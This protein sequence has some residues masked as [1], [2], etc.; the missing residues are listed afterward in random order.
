MGLAVELYFDAETE[1]AVRA[2]RELVHAAGVPVCADLQNSRPHITLAV[3]E[4][5]DDTGLASAVDRFI[6][7]EPSFCPV[8]LST[9]GS[10]PTEK[11]VLFLAPVPTAGLLDLHRSVFELLSAAG[12]VGEF[13]QPDH[14]VPHC[15]IEMRLSVEELT[16]AFETCWRHFRPIAG[17]LVEAGIVAYP[18]AETLYRIP[19]LGTPRAR[20][21]ERA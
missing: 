3:V 17:H 2:L 21:E 4:T 10:F 16:T 12:E 14:W 18:P 5:A 13:Y 19:L 1:T 11:G 9:V 7:T 6:T 8:K 20:A 15:T